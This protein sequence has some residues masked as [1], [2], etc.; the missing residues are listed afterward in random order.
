MGIETLLRPS[1]LPCPRQSKVKPEAVTKVQ[2]SVGWK[3]SNF[4]NFNQD[5]LH[6]D[7]KSAFRCDTVPEISQFGS[8][9]PEISFREKFV[10][11]AYYAAPEL[12]LSAAFFFLN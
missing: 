3:G 4:Q 6:A 1:L 12:F 7:L 11:L 9:S 8:I 2:R 10:D 5:R